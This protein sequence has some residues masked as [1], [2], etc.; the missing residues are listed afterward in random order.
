MEGPR[1]EGRQSDKVLRERPVLKQPVLGVLLAGVGGADDAPSA[2]APA[3][4]AGT[5]G[6]TASSA[7]TPVPACPF[8][9]KWSYD[10][11]RS[12]DPAS[13]F[14]PEESPCDRGPGEVCEGVGDGNPERR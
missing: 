14:P 9:G 3:P 2:T 7:E 4:A 1:I 10:P 6:Q 11:R 12:D 13:L 5:A 8:T